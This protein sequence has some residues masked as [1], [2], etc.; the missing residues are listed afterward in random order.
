M[1]V[2]GGIG[3]KVCISTLVNIA[4]A[5]YPRLYVRPM[6]KHEF[7]LVTSAYTMS[8]N[9][10]L[11]D[12][13]RHSAAANNILVREAVEAYHAVERMKRPSTCG[14]C[15]DTDVVPYCPFFFWH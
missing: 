3:R 1:Y 4:V 12:Y 15:T 5:T 9:V 11:Y 2:L 14:F 8:C 7:E 6:E 13:T 10:P